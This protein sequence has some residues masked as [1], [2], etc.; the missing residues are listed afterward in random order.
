MPKSKKQQPKLPIPAN[1][2]T[3]TVKLH[4]VQAHWLRMIGE[5]K[6]ISIADLLS[7][8]IQPYLETELPNL[9]R[10]MTGYYEAEQSSPASS[11]G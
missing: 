6:N 7:P 8:L 3:G 2:G 10:S 9:F 1:I 4:P 5:W 11:S